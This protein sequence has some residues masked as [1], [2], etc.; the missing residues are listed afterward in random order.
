MLNK[1]LQTGGYPDV[2]PCR[3]KVSFIPCVQESDASFQVCQ[4][5]FFVLVERKPVLQFLMLQVNRTFV[6]INLPESLGK[7]YAA[8]HWLDLTNNWQFREKETLFTY[9]PLYTM[10]MNG[11]YRSGQFIIFLLLFMFTSGKASGQEIELAWKEIRLSLDQVFKKADTGNRS[12]QLENLKL[13]QNE[14]QL[15]DAKAERL[16]ELSAEAEYARVSNMPIFEDGLFSKPVYPPVIHNSF[17]LQGEGYLN[18]YNGKKLST[19]IAEEELSRD[20]RQEN[21][22]N[23]AAEVRLRAAGYYL[24]L[25][26][27]FEFRK[28]LRKNIEEQAQRLSQIREL[29]HNGVVLRSDVLRAELLLSR[30]KMNLLETENGITLASQKL[31]I[32]L[33]QPEGS[34]IRPDTIGS[35]EG[36]PLKSYEELLS[37]ARSHSYHLRISEKETELSR[38]K[39]K[40][41]KANVLPRAGLFA[42][43]GYSYPQI[44]LYPYAD[45]GYAIGQAG[46]RISIPIS[47]AYH[48]KHQASA[49]AVEVEQQELMHR[50]EED[51]LRQR[52]KEAYTRYTEAVTRIEVAQRSISQATEN[53]RIVNNTYFNQ[54]ALLTDLLDAD[55]QLLQARFDLAS[56][57]VAAS[58]QYYQLQ[59][60]IGNL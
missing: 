40:A 54:L 56:A 30:Q 59:K 28:L 22:N 41:V 45:A 60:A 43:Y 44:L 5:P 20:I 53:F 11:S 27:N 38:L 24:E 23:T 21:K 18:L 6:L 47:A 58:F 46:L 31:N 55:S 7:T 37:E 13:R 19:K 2:V 29:H 14:E 17:K 50:Q 1:M 42:G 36:F 8:F 9:L 35:E 25:Q 16:P 15:K 4:L 49:A 52:V 34:I 51:A 57:K 33:G 26:R 3:Q 12:L 32:L 10:K 48:N 39:L